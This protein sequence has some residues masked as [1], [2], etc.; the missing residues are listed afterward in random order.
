MG[1][2]GVQWPSSDMT[3]GTQLAA[4]RVVVVDRNRRIGNRTYGGVGGR[5]GQPRMLPD[6]INPEVRRDET[7]DVAS[8]GLDCTLAGHRI[9]LRPIKQGWQ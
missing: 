1:A 6:F 3:N 7:S 5:R 4:A 2:Q 9:R 8:L